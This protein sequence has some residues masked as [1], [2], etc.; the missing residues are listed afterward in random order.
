MSDRQL[1]AIALLSLWIAVAALAVMVL[2]ALGWAQIRRQ[3]GMLLIVAGAL[4]VLPGGAVYRKALPYKERLLAVVLRKHSAPV[5]LGN[6]CSVFPENNIWNTP[7][8]SLPVDPNS[9]AY[10]ESMGPDLPLHADFGAASGIPYAV[11]TGDVPPAQVAAGSAESD[12]GPYR[13]PD[14]APVEPGSDRHVVILGAADC[15]LYELYAA[16][17]KGTG[18]WEAGSAAIFDLRSNR[19]RPE[20]WTSADAAGLPIFPAL[21]RF[22]EV[23]SGSIRHALRFTT[24]RTRRAFVWPARHFASQSNDPRLP[25]MGMR[26]RLKASVP[27]D[28]FSPE[29]RVILTALKQY[30]MMLADNGGPW[31]LTGTPDSRWS[32][33]VISELRQVKGADFEAVDT[34]TLMVD[35]NSGE[36]RR[37]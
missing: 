17:R 29:T 16:E 37:P 27:L 32:T 28:G 13:L 34:S 10:I 25:P 6:T 31:Y 20:G 3:R 23:R 21:L 12:A 24:R 2:R 26:F 15:R 8:T 36:A 30:G 18:Q 9:A 5:A 1:A 11:T 19:L 22:D 4:M 35:R 14:D 7:V 33:R